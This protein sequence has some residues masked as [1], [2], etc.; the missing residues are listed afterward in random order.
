MDALLMP[1][2]TFVMAV[3]SGC[4]KPGSNTSVNVGGI[5]ELT[6]EGVVLLT[7][8]KVASKLKP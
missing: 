5:L 3:K 6:E 7:V 4:L 8:E 2:F 1:L